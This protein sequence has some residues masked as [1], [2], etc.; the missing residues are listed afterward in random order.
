M[1][2]SKPKDK[3]KNKEKT[4][5][6]N[7]TDKPKNPSN[8]SNQQKRKSNPSNI[9]KYA[10]DA[11]GSGYVYGSSGQ[12]LTDSQYMEFKRNHPKEVTNESRKW[13]HKKVY[14]C[15][16]LV[17]RAFEQEGINLPHNADEAW[18]KTKWS[19]KGDMKNLPKD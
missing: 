1:K 2:S 10:N 4:K 11:L 16:G 17:K 7:K 13:R 5:D 8:P 3:T 15:S 12:V 18:R 19:Q 6:E 9:V 14:D